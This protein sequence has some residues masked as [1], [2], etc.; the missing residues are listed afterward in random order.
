MCPGSSSRGSPLCTLSVKPK[1]PLQNCPS[2]E[3]FLYLLRCF[4]FSSFN[5][6]QKPPPPPPSVDRHCSGCEVGRLLAD[7]KRGQ[8]RGRTDGGTYGR[9][10]ERRLATRPDP[11][12]ASQLRITGRTISGG[13]HF[14]IALCSG[15]I[16]P[17]LSLSLRLTSQVF[18][19]GS[20]PPDD[21]QRRRI[22]VTIMKI[23]GATATAAANDD[24]NDVIDDFS[25]VH[26]LRESR[27]QS[28]SSLA[29]SLA[30]RAD[31]C[32]SP[33]R[34]VPGSE[35]GREGQV[36]GRRIGET[37]P[38][39]SIVG[40]EDGEGRRHSGRHG[41]AEDDGRADRG[42]GCAS[43]CSSAMNPVRASERGRGLTF[44]LACS[45]SLAWPWPCPARAAARPW[46]SPRPRPS[47]R[48]CTYFC[49]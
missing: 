34:K 43:S 49:S 25:V 1:C 19:N 39:P 33:R 13:G 22:L 11:D 30:R 21:P 17:F 29:R 10:T 2:C 20:P 7:G 8:T 47:S 32:L 40:D 9:R 24:D 5:S 16:T 41:T 48:L 31:V 45:L 44:C 23:V 36:D 14:E 35:G 42:Q 4:F 15:K 3:S 38:P 12:S 26:S 46:P 6:R 27:M 18:R 37:G 28:A